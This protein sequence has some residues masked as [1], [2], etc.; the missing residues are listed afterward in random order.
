MRVVEMGK[1]PEKEAVC[2]RCNT[3]LAYTEA[4]V[5]HEC[6]EVF[7]NFHSHSDIVCPVCGY[8]ITLVVDGTPLDNSGCP[9]DKE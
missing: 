8:V 5:K 9:K 6:E 1:L 4:D 2:N 7:G 3:V